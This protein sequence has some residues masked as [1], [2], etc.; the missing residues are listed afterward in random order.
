MD[1]PADP[2]EILGRFLRAFGVAPD[3]IPGGPAERAALYQSLVTGRSL[4]VVLDDAI[5]AAQVSPLLPASANSVA[6]VTSRWRLAGLLARGA[7]SI[8]LERL[9]PEAALELLELS[10]GHDRIE[11]DLDAARVLVELCARLPIALSVAAARLA[12]R[13]RRPLTEMVE[14]L[15]HE[16]HR[17][18]ALSTEDDMT[19][20]AALTLSYQGL[21]PSAARLYR[22][23]GIY[24]GTTF[25][26]WGAAAA[27]GLPRSEIRPLL[28]ILTDA[29]LLDDLPGDS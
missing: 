14:A 24:P 2:T 7:R 13:P 12:T 29:N 21:P 26:T 22:L 9:S 23:L 15:T 16:R 1:D 3:R 8:Q 19:I 5:S 20:R 17:L 10:L 25:S 11:E 4:V 28:D 27:A 6:L 18:S